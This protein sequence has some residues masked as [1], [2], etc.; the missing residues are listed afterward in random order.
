MKA[1]PGPAAPRRAARSP[2][3]DDPRRRAIPDGGRSPV[4]VLSSSSTRLG[5]ALLCCL[6]SVGS[7]FAQEAA[8]HPAPVAEPSSATTDPTV[9]ARRH[10]Q[11]GVK[12]YRDA[13]YPGAL[14]EFE[15][16][17]E[18]KPGP[19]SLQN[20]ALSQK[21]L[22][23]YGE[24]AETLKLLLE[25]HGA[26]LS[27]DERR[28]MRLAVEELEGLIGSVLV[29]VEPAN[30]RVTINGQL[31]T[32]EQRGKRLR[33]NVGEHT[34]VAEAPGYTRATKTFRVA[35]GQ[36]DVPVVLALEPT[37]GFVEVTAED[38]EAVIAIDGKPLARGRFSGPLSPD[39]EHLV[40][41]YRE[42][43]EPFEQSVNLELGKTLLIRVPR[44]ERI[45]GSE[46]VI[47]LG[48]KKG[49]P[50]PPKDKRHLGWY[51]L[52][53][54]SVLGT[55][56]APLDFEVENARAS[57]SAGAIGVRG[58]YRF[59]KSI[60]ADLMLEFSNLKV[61][62][63]CDPERT[64]EAETKCDASNQISRSYQVKSVRLGANLRFLSSGEKVRF[65]VGA[66]TGI[67]HHTLELD[68]LNS[69][70]FPEATGGNAAGVDPYF[71]L[72]AGIGF[73]FGHWMIEAAAIAMV[74]GTSSLSGTFDGKDSGDAFGETDSTLPVAG[75]SLRFGYSQWLPR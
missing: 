17:Y 65:I 63:A 31:V 53:S 24:A 59:W 11:S 10:F 55:G 3:G 34:V 36:N 19:S 4:R 25:R 64:D 6:L 32:P 15:A 16:A 28:A 67:V 29:T 62:N 58:G 39:E 12:L 43:Y 7:A 2:T 40:Q 56:T 66:G 48:T 1:K 30:A 54:V 60:S 47:D 42:G 50:P 70:N 13:N 9:E 37:G 41:V 71:A 14:A 26:E 8:P 51:G 21:A 5:G 20:V 74:D 27:E 72:E 69:A 52:A 57:T 18:L 68:A 45:E 23:R 44:G 49:L 35:G 75:L 61:D 73:N 46:P 33:V 38:P 22:F